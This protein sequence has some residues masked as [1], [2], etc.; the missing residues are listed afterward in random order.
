MYVLS[1]LAEPSGYTGGT[2][3]R[4][5]RGQN[6]L[7]YKYQAICSIF[8]FITSYYTFTHT[9]SVVENHVETSISHPF[10][11]DHNASNIH[12]CCKHIILHD[13]PRRLKDLEVIIHESIPTYEDSRALDILYD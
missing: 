5:P 10:Y 6:S 8:L 1:D 3:V 12:L 13:P 7:G 11:N 4:V 9:H 2:L